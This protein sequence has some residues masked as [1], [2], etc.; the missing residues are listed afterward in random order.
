MNGRR[1]VQLHLLRHAH[2]G[3]PMKWN[4][5]DDARPLSE[6]GRLQAER[7]G[8]LLA[9]AGFDPD[10]IVASPK[11]RA[12]DTA[13]LVA[14][15]LSMPV[16][17]MEALAGPL[18]IETVE[19]LLDSLGNPS[20]PLLVGHDPDFSELAAALVGLTELPMRKGALVRI[21]L[22]RPLEPGSG[23]LRWLLPPELLATPD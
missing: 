6:K 7:L 12:L 13:R 11:L 3:D 22:I 19:T 14:T 23:T 15:P 20:R 9:D 21:D 18:D 16:R 8:L 17:V 4:G 10:A 5:P 1:E 2:A